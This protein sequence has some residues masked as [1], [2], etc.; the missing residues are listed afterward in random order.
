M[1][2]FDL[3]TDIYHYYAAWARRN[4]HKPYLAK[5]SDDEDPN[6]G[7]RGLPR[8]LKDRERED[9]R[10]GEQG[11]SKCWDTQACAGW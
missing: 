4:G 6:E 3:S 8:P 7:L 2:L 10:S 5:H 9:N 1:D 11:R